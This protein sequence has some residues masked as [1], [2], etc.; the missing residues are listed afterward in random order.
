MDL[1]FSCNEFQMSFSPFSKKNKQDMTTFS[2]NHKNFKK[3]LAVKLLL[4]YCL[5]IIE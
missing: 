4:V 1:L 2:K 3:I 5:I